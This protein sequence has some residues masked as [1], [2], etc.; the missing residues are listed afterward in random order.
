M[1]AKKIVARFQGD[2]N[3][4][5][6]YERN[7][8]SYMQIP[9]TKEVQNDQSYNNMEKDN[10]GLDTSPKIHEKGKVEHFEKPDEPVASESQ[11]E[12]ITDP[13]SCSEKPSSARRG[14]STSL[15]PPP[16]LPKDE[17]YIDST[18]PSD[19]QMRA[20]KG[21]EASR[22]SRNEQPNVSANLSVSKEMH[23][24]VYNRSNSNLE[25]QNIMEQ[26]NDGKGGTEGEEIIARREAL[27]SPV[28][29]PPRTSS[30]E[31]RGKEILSPTLSPT[32]EKFDLKSPTSPK[33]PQSQIPSRPS[34]TGNDS[35]DSRPTML[36][37]HPLPKPE[38][39]PEL[40]FDF[41]RFL[42][43]LRHRTADPVAKFLRSFLNEFGKKQW[44][45]HEQVKI[46]SDFLEFIS[47][48]M[49]Q[50]EVWRNVS[51]VEFDNAR[52]GMEKLV[53]N[54][55][56]S[57]TF[58]PVIPS[59]EPLGPTTQPKGSQLGTRP[60]RRGQ[61]QEDVER[62]DVLAQKMR[63]YAW[64]SESHLDIKPLGD[65]GRKFLA[66]AQQGTQLR[67]AKCSQRYS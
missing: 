14:S 57:Q 8:K 55:L 37:K 56:Y 22:S 44:M 63:I 24:H 58:S 52:E 25:I 59:T 20:S 66:L 67:I 46:I 15:T 62:D 65:K 36:A 30:L 49:A 9:S 31:T 6:D 34:A 19:A 38:P 2:V 32:N 48:K 43:Q 12:A 33:S 7:P 39:E 27:T 35:N 61:H 16:P 50:C 11:N 42:E 47:R 3:D 53:M 5:T 21:H 45:A 1:S 41:H 4:S 29:P 51:E 40:P 28:L 60:D 18:L 17:K 26:F 13:T 54:R 23:K 10:E 64:V